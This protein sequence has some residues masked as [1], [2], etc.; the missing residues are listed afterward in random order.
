MLFA[1]PNHS[2]ESVFAC[3]PWDFP[4]KVPSEAMES[5]TAFR[6]WSRNPKTRHCFFSGMEGI[7]G[8]MRVSESNPI[9]RCHGLVA[10]YDAN[11]P[12]TMLNELV[13][14]CPTEFLPN[15]ASRTFSGGARLAWLLENPVLVPDS[16]SA[17]AFM[18]HAARV[19]KLDKMLPGFDSKAF[20]SPDTYYEVGSDWRSYHDKPITETF[21]W[22]WLAESG[23]RLRW[24]P[25][26][27]TE[28]PLADVHKE[29]ERQFPGAWGNVPFELG[30]RTRRFW[31]PT[32]TNPSSAILRDGG[33]QCFAGDQPF[34]SW[35]T[36]LGNK[37]VDRFE[38]DKLGRVLRDTF[39][40]GRRFWCKNDAGTW[41]DES[42][43]GFARALK[44]DYGLDPRVPKG[45]TCS[46]VDRAIQAVHKNKRV[47]AALPYVHMPTGFIKIDG[48]PYLNISSVRC[49]TPAS[50]RGEWGERFPW[51]ARFLEEL[52][53][54]RE[55]LQHLL[56]W[57]KRF[58][59]GGLRLKPS[60]G[61]A[62]FTVGP[63]GCGKTLLQCNIIAKSVGGHVD[64]SDYIVEGN[65]FSGTFVKKPLMSIDDSSP[66]S[67]HRRHSKYS[68]KI[69]KLV[70]NPHQYFNEKYQ[71]AGQVTWLGRVMVSLNDDPESLQMLPD[72]QQS[73]LDKIMILRV[74]R[75]SF[76]FPEMH[77][78]EKI[79]DTEL[80]HLLRWL[81]H[82]T[83]PQE[84]VGEARF[85]V[86]SYYHPSTHREALES[87]YNYAFI[88][89]LQMFLLEYEASDQRG[90]RDCW[91]GT[92]AELLA[93]MRNNEL[94][95]TVCDEYKA[96]SVG[97]HLRALST[98]GYDVVVEKDRHK[99]IGITWRIGFNLRPEEEVEHAAP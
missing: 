75:P 38:A 48:D 60:L 40:D 44:V 83:P 54:P 51:L 56:A 61:Q 78:L 23:K 18:R 90:S 10:D 37:F 14:T 94:V 73:L 77:K 19:M 25:D 41:L 67:D 36:L 84:V 52:Y 87:S 6:Q 72:L 45:A 58:Y 71:C 59:E 34:V 16:K 35:R 5:K 86:K 1:I 30:R 28:I 9:Y 97:R 13:D 70:A 27:D 39:F 88:E 2:A 26:E 43:E 76:E 42:T 21:A 85:G 49:M 99:S 81:L 65:E 20:S 4:L 46:E 33:F 31:D 24:R 64:S 66:A 95:K 22:L 79:I 89:I 7:H 15:F 93:Q 96:T 50:R 74:K 92:A 63:V 55:Q 91:R 62:V 17:R 57:W 8:S 69:K 68:S 82:W 32:A 29:I 53:N 47:M 80:P 12:A 3:E 11:I 98:Q